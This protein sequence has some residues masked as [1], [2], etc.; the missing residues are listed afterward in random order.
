VNGSRR[1]PEVERLVAAYRADLVAAGMF[2]EHPVTSPA[3][4]FLA[5]V[6]VEGWSR[7]SLAEQCATSL[8]DR[9]VV[10]WLMVTG[11]VRPSPDYLVLG[12]PYLGEVAARHHRDFHAHFAATAGE[13]GFD[14]RSIRLQ[15]SA[16]V[17]VGV[18]AGGSPDRL[19][20]AR[21]D[22]GREQLIAAIRRHRPDSNGVRALTTALFG[23]EATL[24]HAGVIDVP[25]RKRHPDKSAARA[26]EWATVAPRLAATLQ[27]TSSRCGS[28][29]GPAR[30]C[31]SRGWCA[32]SPAGWPS[33]RRRSAPSPTFAAP[34][35]SDTSA[36]SPAGPRPAAA[37]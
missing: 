15:W 30:W 20:K 8:K 16:T 28:R 18:L 5:R 22:A 4:S 31:A 33:R 13:L 35:S 29:C 6:G 1:D 17:K 32:S 7:L 19:S 3:R 24:F 25:P 34:T 9:R 21:L 23:A 27:A 2:A 10:G 36:T 14:G 37:S 11:R 12:R 26:R